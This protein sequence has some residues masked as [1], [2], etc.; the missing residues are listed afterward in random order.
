M[1][2]EA[3]RRCLYLTRINKHTHG[4]GWG[5]KV[6]RHPAQRITCWL[7]VGAKERRTPQFCTPCLLAY[8]IQSKLGKGTVARRIPRFVE[9]ARRA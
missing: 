5:S 4:G 1:K 6:D 8:Q 7:R 9:P 3:Y 2:T